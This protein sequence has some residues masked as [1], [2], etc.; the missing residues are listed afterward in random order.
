MLSWSAVT[1]LLASASADGTARIWDPSSGSTVHLLSNPSKAPVISV[2]WSPDGTV[3]VTGTWQGT[4]EVWDGHTGQHLAT[5]AGPPEKPIVGRNPY[6]VWGVAWSPDGH[7]VASTRYDMHVLVWDAAS[8]HLRTS[9]IPDSQ[10]NGVA[11]RPDSS[12]F[13]SSDD[14]GTIQ[15]WDVRASSANARML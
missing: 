9:L 10:P 7:T 1:D 12:G 13:A 14:G 11:W 4:V 3:L 15:L 2:D 5:W 6:A 8:G